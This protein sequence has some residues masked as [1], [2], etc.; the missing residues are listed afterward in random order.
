[1]RRLLI[2]I[3]V[4]NAL[5]MTTGCGEN[6]PN[7]PVPVDSS[8][9]TS[10]STV[11]TPPGSTASPSG[12]SKGPAVSPPPD[13]PL[14]NSPPS[15]PTSAAKYINFISGGNKSACEEA[16][17][18][19]GYSNSCTIGGGCCFDGGPP[20]PNCPSANPAHYGA[21]VLK[22]H[23]IKIW[24]FIGTTWPY[25]ATTCPTSVGCTNESEV[26]MKKGTTTTSNGSTVT[27][28]DLFSCTQVLD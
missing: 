16:V 13:S 22:T 4:V 21:C 18:S 20:S 28:A 15:P 3:L 17:A 2:T 1:M 25:T 10:A 7:Q 27:A 12:D 5:S 6:I 8:S 11:A 24:V 26:C 9:S 19:Y 23:P 14:P